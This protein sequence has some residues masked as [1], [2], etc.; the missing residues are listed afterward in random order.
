MQQ[1]PHVIQANSLVALSITM[2]PKHPLSTGCSGDTRQV[3]SK[4]K[5]IKA[6]CYCPARWLMH[7]NG[8]PC[9]PHL[10]LPHVAQ[11]CCTAER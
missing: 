5:E 1:D 6:W 10:G 7:C 2:S 9:S 4:P 11:C 8:Q 3:I